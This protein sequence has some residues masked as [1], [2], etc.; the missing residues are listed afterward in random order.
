MTS[1]KG[2]PA[3]WGSNEALPRA[4]SPSKQ[5]AG[6][7]PCMPYRQAGPGPRTDWEAESANGLFK[8]NTYAQRDKSWPPTW[9]RCYGDVTSMH[10]V[11]SKFPEDILITTSYLLSVFFKLIFNI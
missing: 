5:P 2:A 6:Q 4:P 3:C 11:Y 1:Q 7:N 8:H 9:R 10:M